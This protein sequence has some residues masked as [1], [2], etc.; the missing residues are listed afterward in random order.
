MHPVG[1]L[2]CITAA[3]ALVSLRKSP[4]TSG[5]HARQPSLTARGR[6][7]LRAGDAPVAERPDP[8]VL[9][10]AKDDE[11]QQLYFGGICAGI[12]VGTAVCVGGLNGLEAALPDG[13]F[14]AW[15]DGRRGESI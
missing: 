3:H 9:V 14:A 1:L 13:W 11:S 8:A 7:A 5:V 15:R 2:M 12:A 10:S 4:R 6:V